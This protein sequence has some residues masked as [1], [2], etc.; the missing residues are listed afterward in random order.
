MHETALV[1]TANVGLGNVVTA[2]GDTAADPLEVYRYVSCADK[3]KL[4]AIA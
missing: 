2:C 4:N 1:A 3:N